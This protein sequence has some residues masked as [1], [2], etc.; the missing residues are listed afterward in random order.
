[1]GLE[2]LTTI[3]IDKST[4]EDRKVAEVIAT[5]VSMSRQQEQMFNN[6]IDGFG[7]CKISLKFRR[8]M[9]FCSLK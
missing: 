5:Q 8:K 1:L 2:L 9:L 7:I 4:E 3:D 6:A